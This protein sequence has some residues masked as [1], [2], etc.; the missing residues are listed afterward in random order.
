MAWGRTL[1]LAGEPEHVALRPWSTTARLGGTWLKACGEGGRYEAALL[2]LLR[3]RGEDAVVLPDAVDVDR[4]YLALPDGGTPLRELPDARPRWPDLLAAH[5]QLQ[6]RLAPA[7]D[8][9]VARGVPD[10]RPAVVV[11]ALEALLDRHPLAPDLRDDV[12]T[13]LPA[14]ADDAAALRDG[15]VPGSLQHDDLHDGNVLV[16]AGGTPRLIDWGDASVGHPFG[17]L[18]VCLRVLR[19]RQ[20]Y[21]DARLDRCQDAYLEPWSDL[22]GL[23]ELRALAAA[24]QRVQVVGRALCWER[25]LRCADDADRAEWGDPVTG[26]LEVLAGRED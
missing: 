21:D 18:L 20:G 22:A 19:H 5:A 16:D 25:A 8:D 10:L 9:L 26:W 12:R 7:A 23:P 11:D 13:A 24:A 2:A 17:V 4:G 1:G 14:L 3:D 6:R 15:P